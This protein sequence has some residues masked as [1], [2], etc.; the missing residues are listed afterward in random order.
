MD[1][2]DVDSIFDIEDV[3]HRQDITPVT[4]T[5]PTDPAAAR[6]T[7]APV[8]SVGTEVGPLDSTC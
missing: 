3:Q 6:I 8:N 7:A 5:R 2:V 1:H 4:Y